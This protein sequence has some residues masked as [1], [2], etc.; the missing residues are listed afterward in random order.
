MII[1]VFIKMS[2]YIYRFYY[3]VLLMLKYSCNNVVTAFLNCDAIFYNT[4]QCDVVIEFRVGFTTLLSDSYMR[5]K[6]HQPQGGNR[7]SFSPET[8]STAL[9]QLS[10]NSFSKG[11]NI[12]F[13]C[14]IFWFV[15][16]SA[17]FWKKREKS[18][19]A[20]HRVAGGS[21]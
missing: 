19:K 20:L 5:R 6:M 12:L 18:E 8:P 1:I 3:N 10:S 17:A 21:K 4:L 16:V 13:F 2:I 15:F 9:I 14:C 11:Y 7:E